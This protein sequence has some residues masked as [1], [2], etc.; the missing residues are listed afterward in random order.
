MS[1]RELAK[2]LIERIKQHQTH[3]LREENLIP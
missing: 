1:A 3:Y 2:R